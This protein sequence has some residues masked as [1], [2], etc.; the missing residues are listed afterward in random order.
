VRDVDGDTLTALGK[1]A[2]VRRNFFSIT[3]IK[4]S[5]GLPETAN[6]WNDVGDTTIDVIDGETLSPV[7]RTYTGSATLIQVDSLPLIS[8]L[9]VR[10]VKVQLY[11]VHPDVDALIR[12]YRLKAAR[13]EIHRGLYQVNARTVVAEPLPRFIGKV[14]RSEIITGAQ[15]EE[16]AHELSCVSHT[17][18]LTRTST[19]KRSNECQKLRLSTDTFF[20][21]A[22]IVP[23][24]Q[25]F[26]GADKGPLNTVAATSPLRRGFL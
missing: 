17:V 21:Y 14:D 9:S 6:F 24:F 18:E 4:I 16:S 23:E 20:K 12:L 25:L 15:G 19:E 8:D 5:T 22:G 3:A 11:P 2:L 13:I 26:W 7:S 10:T 1:R